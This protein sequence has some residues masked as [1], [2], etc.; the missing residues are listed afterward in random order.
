MDRIWQ[1]A[2]D[3]YGPRY[4]WA[5]YGISIPVLLVLYLALALPVVASEG[6]GRYVEA[7]AVA[8]VA[9]MVMA[10]VIVRPGMSELHLIEQWAAGH[11]VD[12]VRALGATYTWARRTGPRTTIGNAVLL[13]AVLV[14]VG[15]IAGA[16]GSRLVQYGI[17]GVMFGIAMMLPG[18]HSFPEASLR[19]A[20]I[21]IVG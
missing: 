8:V 20:R 14:L 6:S 2:W 1:W 4:S 15:T 11:D 9:A 19:P 17:V 16:S 3:R 13:P 12:R 18:V 21:D 7:A 10:S 5:I